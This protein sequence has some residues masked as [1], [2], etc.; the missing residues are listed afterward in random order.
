[1]NSID[2]EIIVEVLGRGMRLTRVQG[3][4]KYPKFEYIYLLLSG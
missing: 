2:S 3:A 4:N 1:M